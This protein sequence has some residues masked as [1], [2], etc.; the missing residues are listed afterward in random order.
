MWRPPV[1]ADDDYLTAR[2]LAAERYSFQ[3]LIMAAMLVAPQHLSAALMKS[4][5]GLAAILRANYSAP[6]SY[7]SPASGQ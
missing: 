3:P 5:P 6:G 2:A 7:S 4:Y 1:P